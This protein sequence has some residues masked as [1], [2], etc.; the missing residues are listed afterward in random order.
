MQRLQRKETTPDVSA[1]ESPTAASTG[2]R[3]RSSD[4]NGELAQT[5]HVW[6]ASRRHQVERR[7]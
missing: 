7:Q 4:W 2:G 3:V 5:R 6:R 1:F